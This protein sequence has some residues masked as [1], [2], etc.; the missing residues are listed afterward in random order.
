[1]IGHNASLKSARPPASRAPALGD[2]ARGVR[3]E[4]AGDL[5]GALAAYEAAHA[6]AP[7][8]PDILAALAALAARLEMREAAARLWAEVARLR[9]ERL[10][11]VDG[12][13][14]ALRELGRF[15][16]AVD[17]LR[18]ALLTHPEEPRLWNS[19]G[20]TLTQ[21]G[22]AQVAIT[23]L[24]EA[25]RLDPRFAAALYN[26]GAARF[27]LGQLALAHAD[28][29]QAARAAKTAAEAAAIAFARSTL[30]LARGDLATG[31]EAYETRLSRRWPK[32]S[33]FEA[34]GR[35]WRPADTLRGKRL[36]IVAEQ[37]LGDEL[38]F[39]SV[40]PDV[41]EALG[42]EGALSLAVDPRLVSLFSRSF[43]AA[44]V[45][46]HATGRL[47]PRNLRSAPDVAAPRGVDLWAPM[48][49]LPRR[50]RPSLRDFPAAHGYLR[51][52]PRRVAHW[53]AWLGDGP[54]AVGVTWRSGKLAGDRRRQYPPLSLWAPLLRT[55]GL[56]FVN[57]QYG[58]CADELADLAARA[59]TPIL[60]PPGLD[61]RD[62]LEGLAALTVA[63]D[64]TL[65]VSNA[66]AA[67]AGACGAP[68]AV[69]G[70]PANW[71][72]LGTDAYPWYPQA[73]AFN[74]ASFGDWAPA[75]DAAA[76]RLTRLAAGRPA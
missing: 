8:D 56:R 61:L 5:A 4:R 9:P 76:E 68:L 39:A 71:T 11:A 67:L 7:D 42:P 30:L 74:T 40:L 75:M 55:P 43:P 47:G 45:S 64:L 69:I 48:G 32:A 34:P 59:G 60:E 36:L 65:V 46:A 44:Q 26:R 1:M 70:G 25:V 35:R 27:D 62:D 23:F 73:Q 21:D 41:T 58:D 31:W 52:D 12:E 63:L 57:L 33:V 10:E 53:R 54:A 38:M 3:L 20:V 18:H 24:D 19:L 14:Q 22:Q 50:F 6:R 29:G 16:E 17:R 37:G 28:F 15:D 66:T 72:R 13:A 2:L 49:S 51:P